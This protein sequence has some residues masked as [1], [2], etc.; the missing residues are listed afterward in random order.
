MQHSWADRSILPRKL[1]Q[2]DSAN[3]LNAALNNR[4]IDPRRQNISRRG[5]LPEGESQMG[6]RSILI[7]LVA[8]PL[9]ARAQSSSDI[10]ACEADVKVADERIAACTDL[11]TRAKATGSFTPRSLAMT[12]SNR[13]VAWKDKGD[14]D[15]A[16][17][18]FGEAILLSPDFAI[19]FSN[20]G[21]VWSQK[22]D[23]GRAIADYSEAIRLDPRFAEAYYNR[24]I[25]WISRGEN[26]RAIADFDQA[27]RL[28]SKLAAN[29]LVGRGTSW[30]NKGDTD[31]AI[32]DFSEA[33]RLDESLP[34]ARISRRELWRYRGEP[35]KAIAELD[36]AI[37]LVSTS[38]ELFRQRGFAWRDK[39]V[40]DKALADMETAARLNPQ[41][42][43]LRVLGRLRFN[44]GDFAGSAKAL[45]VEVAQRPSYPYA[46]IWLYLAQAR[47]GDETAA[48]AQM[49]ARRSAYGSNAWPTQVM[50]YY[51]G[52]IDADALF[53]AARE[54]ESLRPAG[55][56][57]E[58][59][60]YAGE[61]QLLR[62]DLATARRLLKAA[63]ED[64]PRNFDEL[65]AAIAELARLDAR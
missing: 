28:S 9:F 42:R 56:R 40:F 3:Q 21:T 22:G 18:D 36:E 58:G 39:R 23:S 48:R 16:V 53:A 60:F 65:P 37:R 13:G 8:L 19:A 6:L 5:R 46:S 27:I 25:D 14:S 17:A 1:T 29:A 52:V 63:T 55:Q 50:D 34:V 49:Q 62:G 4:R 11:I 59:N 31:R 35:D 2:P 44:T 45:Y 51:A 15:R 64:C 7:L 26:D 32:A 43:D 33:L 54:A 12:Y 10:I 38:G 57:C 30:R 61:W 20:R 47:A 24:A 41:P